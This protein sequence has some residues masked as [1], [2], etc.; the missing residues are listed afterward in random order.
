MRSRRVAFVLAFWMASLL[1]AHGQVAS[2]QTAPSS[3]NPTVPGSKN[4]SDGGHQVQPGEDPENRLVSPF[5]KHLV[6]DQKHF[7]TA[8]LHFQRKDFLWVAPSLGV[9]ASFVASDSWWAKQVPIS[10]AQTSLHISNYSTYS[11][12]GLGGASFALGHMTHNDHLQE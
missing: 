8:P 4:A 9:A 2:S 5:L 12:I 11:L 1:R 10:H 6:G 7:W 3:N